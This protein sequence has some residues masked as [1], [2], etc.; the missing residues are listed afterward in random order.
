MS[1]STR[2][3]LFSDPMFD[4]SG[5]SLL[6]SSGSGDP[7][8][9]EKPE[10]LSWWESDS[11]LLTNSEEETSGSLMET[12]SGSMDMMDT[13]SPYSMI[14]VPSMSLPSLF[15]S[16]FS[17]D[18]P[19][20]FN[21]KE[22]SLAGL[23]DSFLLLAP[24]PWRMSSLSVEST[25]PKTLPNFVGASTE[26]SS[27]NRSWMMQGTDLYV[28]SSY[29]SLACQEPPLSQEEIEEMNPVLVKISFSLHRNQIK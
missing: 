22:D 11:S 16:A 6:S 8:D 25:S 7:L 20:Q 1:N 13:V 12:S 29:P 3:L 24:N 10:S 9:M 4:L 21:S 26:K 27:W 19:W 28:K 23:L 18:M 17:T 5:Q 15:S 2:A 14:S